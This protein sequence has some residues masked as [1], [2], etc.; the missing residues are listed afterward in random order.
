M[1]T[2]LLD[3]I[4][5]AFAKDMEAVRAKQ[6][7]SVKGKQDAARDHLRK[8]LRTLQ[9][10]RKPLDEHRA[11][12][13]AMKAEVKLPPLD[14]TDIVGAIDRW[15]LQDLSNAMTPLQRMGRLAGPNRSVRFI[16]AVL[17]DDAWVSG[18]SEKGELDAYEEARQSRLRDFHAPLQDTI[19]ARKA[20][21]D[22]ILMVANMALNDLADDCGL[23]RAEF[24]AEAKA[25]ESKAAAEAPKAPPEDRTRPPASPEFEEIWKR[26]DQMVDASVA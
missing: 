20:A 23:S 10:R 2:G 8:A 7:L 24:E 16:D 6:D 4:S 14:K 9:D 19:A 15:K 12:T 22:E 18:F 1:A 21:E 25:F 11:K 17:A 3:D 13:A 26:F 5:G